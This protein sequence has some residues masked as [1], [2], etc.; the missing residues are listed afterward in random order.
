MRTYNARAA[1][2][3]YSWGAV[4]SAQLL[5]LR[6]FSTDNL[7][8]DRAARLAERTAS[9]AHSGA[10]SAF[11]LLGRGATQLSRSE[12]SAWLAGVLATHS[13]GVYR[14]KGLVSFAAEPECTYIVQGVHK[15]FTI[16][17]LPAA[18]D[19]CAA[20]ATSPLCSHCAQTRE[21]ALHR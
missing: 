5:G 11:L 21:A 19:K 18:G 14:L 10:V 3:K 7:P 20:T 6:A 17:R 13:T 9:N 8:A 4:E 15:D 2:I 16:D 1:I 12:F